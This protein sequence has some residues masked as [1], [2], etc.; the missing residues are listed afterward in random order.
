MP[1]DFQKTPAD[2]NRGAW[3]APTSPTTG[4]ADIDVPTAAAINPG[5]TVGFIPLHQ[6]ISNNDTDLGFQASDTANEPSWADSSTFEEFTTTNYGGSASLYYPRDYDDN[7]NLHSLVYDLTDVPGKQVDVVL[8]LDGGVLSGTPVANG[9]FVHGMRLAVAGE[10]NVMTVSES[11]RRTVPFTPSGE[12]AH[13]TIVGPHVLTAIAPS[14][15]ET[16][17]KGR[18]RVTVQNR[19]Y[20]CSDQIRFNTSNVNVIDVLPG[21]FYTVNGTGT[22]TVT[23]TDEGAGTS[24]TV[25][26]TVA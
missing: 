24:T 20:T 21:G 2:R 9:D 13:Y 12:Y 15:W 19:D 3:I 1:I 5:N 8:R 7:S 17:D 16:G 14:T 26:V 18:I 23:I 22:A 6:S 11:V 25:S 4:L 10:Q